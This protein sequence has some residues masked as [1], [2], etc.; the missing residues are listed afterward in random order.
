MAS[1]VECDELNPGN[2]PI[3]AERLVEVAAQAV[4]ED[5]RQTLARPRESESERRHGRKWAWIQPSGF[6]QFQR[7]GFKIETR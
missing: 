7:A 5:E 3:K 1:H 4:L 6:R 2:G